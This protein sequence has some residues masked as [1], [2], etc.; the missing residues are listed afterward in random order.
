VLN[1]R[2]PIIAMTANAMKGDRE[3][4]I[5]AGMDDYLAKPVKAE[6]L[7]RKIE[8]WLHS[9]L[10]EEACADQYAQDDFSEVE[11]MS[12]EKNDDL[13]NGN[14]GIFD[15]SELL[16]RLMGDRDLEKIILGA[17]LEE[18]P[19]QIAELKREIADKNPVNARIQAH[20]IK[21]ASANLAADALRRAA[22]EAEIL[23]EKGDLDG[24]NIL[25]S[26][27]EAEFVLFEGM[28]NKTGMLVNS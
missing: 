2:V 22:H 4:C 16:Q 7:A 18:I 24:M 14:N 23:A 3:I 26:M 15:E 8:Y 1:P 21:G 27:I 19:Q 28:I 5:A 9:S 6:E 13:E 12:G 10:A 25:V 17:F 20:T 11:I